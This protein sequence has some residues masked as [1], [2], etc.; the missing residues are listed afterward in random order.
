MRSEVD[1][2]LHGDEPPVQVAIVMGPKGDEE[3]LSYPQHAPKKD[4]LV[5]KGRI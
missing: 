2:G 1:G 4:D 3:L 5:P